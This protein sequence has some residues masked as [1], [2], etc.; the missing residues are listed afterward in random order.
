MKKIKCF[1]IGIALLVSDKISKE[2]LLN[3]KSKYLN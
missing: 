2:Y 3:L 1:I